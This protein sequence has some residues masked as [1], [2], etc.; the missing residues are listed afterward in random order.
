MLHITSIWLW[1]A[2]RRNAWRLFLADDYWI[3]SALFSSSGQPEDPR[4]ICNYIRA[5]ALRV[6]KNT[7]CKVP[8]SIK[9]SIKWLPKRS[10]AAIPKLLRSFGRRRGSFV[11]LAFLKHV[12]V[13]Q[14]VF[15]GLLFHRLRRRRLSLRKLLRKFYS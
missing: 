11:F 1:C 13:F 15:L 2:P 10:D 14:L 3:L 12:L 4:L 6:L 8:T 5:L 7:R 9:D